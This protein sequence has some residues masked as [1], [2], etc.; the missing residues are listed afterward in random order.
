MNTCRYWCLR[1]FLV[2]NPQFIFRYRC[3]DSHFHVL[4]NTYF[5]NFRPALLIVLR[6][7]V[8][9]IYLVIFSNFPVFNF[10]FFFISKNIFLFPGYK[11]SLLIFDVE[12]HYQLNAMKVPKMVW[13]NHRSLMIRSTT[14]S[15]FTFS[16]IFRTFQSFSYCNLNHT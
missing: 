3:C 16:P 2:W 6:V 1:F 4:V 8:H 12:L 11:Y 5:L 10:P 14:Q 15:T 9:L 13:Y 7:L